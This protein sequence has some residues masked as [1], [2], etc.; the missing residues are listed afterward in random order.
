MD[1]KEAAQ[2]FRKLATTIMNK[3]L[4]F[5]GMKSIALFGFDPF[6]FEIRRVIG[7]RAEVL[8]ELKEVSM[9][10]AF[11]SLDKPTQQLVTNFFRDH[12]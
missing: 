6:V 4:K 3:K 1:G 5:K 11:A 7:E 12:R 10:E 8:E 2:E 9:A